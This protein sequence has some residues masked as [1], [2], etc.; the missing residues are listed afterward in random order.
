MFIIEVYKLVEF[1][2]YPSQDM[3]LDAF[4]KILPEILIDPDKAMRI[5]DDET[6]SVIN[7]CFK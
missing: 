5:I 2:S 4:N 6:H 7:E 3:A 1:I